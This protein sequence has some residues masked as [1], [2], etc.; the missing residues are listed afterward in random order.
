M[1]KEQKQRY[2]KMINSSE[3]ENCRY[4]IIDETNK[5]RIKVT[6]TI[7]QK[8][9]WFGQCIPCEDFIEKSL[10]VNKYD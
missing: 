5:A 10:E 7:K 8:K 3:C 1:P 2:T 9:Y 6:C 4:G